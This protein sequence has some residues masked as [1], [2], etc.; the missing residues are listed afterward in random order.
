MTLQIQEQNVPHSCHPDMTLLSGKIGLMAMVWIGGVMITI[1]TGLTAE[2]LMIP[3]P[4]ELVAVKLK[5]LKRSS[6]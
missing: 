3:T 1:K 5:N 2:Q 4:C 6:L